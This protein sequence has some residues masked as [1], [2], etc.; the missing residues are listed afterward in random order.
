MSKLNIGSQPLS[1]LQ[2]TGLYSLLL[3]FIVFGI[4][5]EL[6]GALQT[7]RKTDVGVYF[8]AAW[9]MRTGNDP[10]SITD[11]RGWHYIYP[12]LFA[13]AMTPLADPPS[14]MNRTGYLPY[15][16]SVGLWYILTLF[17]GFFGVHILAKALE[18]TSRDPVVRE[19]PAFCRRWWALRI[20][21]VLILLIPIGRS[22]V[23]GQI[24]LVIAFLVCGAMAA[25]LY[26]KRFR[27]G[28]W[29]S[30]AICIKIIPAF[31][32]LVPAW[33]RDWKMLSGTVIGLLLGIIIIPVITMGPS[34]VK[35]GYKSFYR[36]TLLAGIKG[37]TEGSRGAELTG[38]TS[39]DSN[40][41]MV[42][43]HNIMYP[44]IKT[45]PDTAAK[46]VRAIHW[47][48]AIIMTLFTL[49][50]TGWKSSRNRFIGKI[51]AD[52]REAL[53]LCALL[54]IM[55]TAS[56]VFHPHYV[57]MLIPLVTVVIAILWNRYSYQ[58]MPLLWK[59]IFWSLVATHLLTSIDS[60]VFLYFRD[61]GFVLFSTILLWAGSVYLLHRT[62][63]V[64][65]GTS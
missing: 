44:N 18:K 21:P 30:A 23:R 7:K 59:I 61:F 27:A 34:K 39:T 5:V 16:A 24:G 54:P 25:L 43:M 13:I 28:L 47:L 62:A 11:D 15:E 56:P 37:D 20:L 26:G 14:G 63:N 50:A 48:I 6:R 57:S 46:G 60:G 40:S 53:F 41:P 31:L 4:V 22:Q 33:R 36:E 3:L 32:L 58:N 29:L 12:P 64:K 35:D 9:A 2:K 8:R 45:R 49:L 10:Y 51:D 52:P 38:I 1:K 42:V 55:F 19:Q 65:L 17:I